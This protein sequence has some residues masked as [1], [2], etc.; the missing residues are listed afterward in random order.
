MMLIMDSNVVLSRYSTAHIELL[1]VTATK[2]Q[3]E[4]VFLDQ[5]TRLSLLV[6]V[7]SVLRNLNGKVDFAVW[8]EAAKDGMGTN[9][10]RNR[11]EEAWGCPKGNTP[12]PMLHE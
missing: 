8:Y 9:P 2:D 6:K 11:G 5:D 1:P 12:M 4:H 3:F 7:V 10:R